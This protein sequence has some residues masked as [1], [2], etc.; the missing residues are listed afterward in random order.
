MN[1][2]H[3]RSQLRYWPRLT[4]GGRGE[5][6]PILEPAAS[7]GQ[8]GRFQLGLFRRIVL[9]LLTVR[10]VW[11]KHTRDIRGLADV[12]LHRKANPQGGMR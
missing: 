5:R 6:T 4:L 11:G 9:I 12:P 8:T 10:P 2:I 7:P 1:A 3:A